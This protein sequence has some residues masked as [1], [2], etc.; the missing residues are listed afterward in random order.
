MRFAD[1]LT[2]A[3]KLLNAELLN[4]KFVLS[5]SKERTVLYWNNDHLTIAERR[6]KYVHNSAR[7]VTECAFGRWRVSLGGCDGWISLG[8]TLR[9]SSCKLFVRCTTWR[10]TSA[11]TTPRKTTNQPNTDATMLRDAARLNRYLIATTNYKGTHYLMKCCWLRFFVTP[12]IY[13]TSSQLSLLMTP[14][15]VPAANSAS[16]T[17]ELMHV[18]S[19]AEENNLKLNCSKSKEIIFTG[20]ATRDKSVLLPAPCLDI[21]QVHKS[22]RSAS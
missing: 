18:Q 13:A 12:T 11:T 22:Q 16:S 17:S 4:W 6:Y 14:I 5:V 19:W 2:T 15:V 7:S 9:P 3:V 21:C 20:R 10:C 1:V 8:R